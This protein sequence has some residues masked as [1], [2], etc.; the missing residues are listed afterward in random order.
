MLGLGKRVEGPHFRDTCLCRL[1]RVST[2]I[3][4]ACHVLVTLVLKGLGGTGTSY[5]MEIISTPT[6]LV[7]QLHSRLTQHLDEVG[8]VGM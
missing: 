3:N 8:S 7:L 6:P 2:H 4:Y 1:I 5:H